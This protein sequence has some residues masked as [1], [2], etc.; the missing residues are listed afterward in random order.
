VGRESRRRRI[1]RRSGGGCS[2]LLCRLRNTTA[3]RLLNGDSRRYDGEG[4]RRSTK[5][6]SSLGRERSLEQLARREE[7]VPSIPLDSDRC[8]L[9]PRRRSRTPLEAPTSKVPLRPGERRRRRTLREMG[10]TRTRL[11]EFERRGATE[12]HQ[13]D[14]R[15]ESRH[16]SGWS[17]TVERL[18]RKGRE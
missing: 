7:E 9:P 5:G 10:W 8:S 12:V 1:R 4:G 17:G 2:F 15:G 13:R 6:V 11:T 18:E 3:L 14:G 16:G